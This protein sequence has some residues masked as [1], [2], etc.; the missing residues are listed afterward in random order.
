LAGQQDST[1]NRVTQS[2]ES[3]NELDFSHTMDVRP[4]LNCVQLTFCHALSSELQYWQVV[5]C[6]AAGMRHSLLND[7][8][9]VHHVT[10]FAVGRLRA[11]ISRTQCIGSLSASV[12]QA[13]S[14]QF[15]QCTALHAQCSTH[16]ASEHE[17]RLQC[18][19]L[20]WW[21]PHLLEGELIISL[22]QQQQRQV[23]T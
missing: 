13:V 10:D 8:S 5:C 3:C 22:L 9:S 23:T 4:L 11:R 6:G 1:L 7:M 15:M 2:D 20:H 21:L 19:N 12:S 16:T 17:G 14:W 18:T